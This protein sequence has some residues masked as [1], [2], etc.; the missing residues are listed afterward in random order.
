[1]PTLTLK[2][3]YILTAL[4]AAGVAVYYIVR[5]LM[6]MHLT[7]S[8]PHIDI[9]SF[10]AAA[11]ATYLGNASPY[12]PAVLQSY[13]PQNLLVIYP[14]LYPPS[15]LPLFSPL[16]YMDIEQARL[17]FLGLNSVLIAG[18]VT[19]LALWTLRLTSSLIAALLM[20]PILTEGS[21]GLWATLWY[22][23]INLVLAFLLLGVLWGL[24]RRQHAVAGILL[25]L[26]ITLKVYPAIF[27]PW[28][29]LR[30]DWK[31]L[32]WCMATLLMLIAFTWATLPHYLWGE[33]LGKVVAYGYGTQPPG[34]MPASHMGN[35]NIH[36][37]LM[38][39]LADTGAVSLGATVIAALLAIAT[40]FTAWKKPEP[41][42]SQFALLLWLTLLIAPLTWL[43]HLAYALFVPVW[44]LAMAWNGRQYVWCVAFA[45]LYAYVL[46]LTQVDYAIPAWRTNLPCAGLLLMWVMM[47][48]Q[49]W[50]KPSAG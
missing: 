40:F 27:L 42:T 37:V 23:Q 4:L 45:A 24:Q 49:V 35:L 15:A 16:A 26:S 47:Q 28:L 21:R 20:I 2:H 5:N 6:L 46:Q 8:P 13:K 18:L 10:S 48:Y 11:Q 44:F 7:G 19:G 30:R 17:L 39:S 25:A 22:G 34:L 29:A 36:G 1:M 32:G 14:F 12:N 38:R 31:S 50:R 9:A 3:K 43:S 41:L 33:W